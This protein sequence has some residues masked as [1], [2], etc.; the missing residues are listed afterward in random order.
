MPATCARKLYR[1]L[2]LPPGVATGSGRPCGC[3]MASFAPSL[4]QTRPALQNRTQLHRLASSSAASWVHR[5]ASPT[6]M[7]NGRDRLVK[8]SPMRPY[9]RG[10]RAPPLLQNKCSDSAIQRRRYCQHESCPPSSFTLCLHVPILRRDHWLSLFLHS[11]TAPAP[12]P[13]LLPTGTR[14]LARTAIAMPRAAVG[15]PQRASDS[16]KRVRTDAAATSNGGGARCGRR[17][18][19]PPGRE[20]VRGG[21]LHGHGAVRPGLQGERQHARVER[22]AAA[23][24]AEARGCQSAI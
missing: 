22:Q 10:W 17:G 21:S 5:R 18:A 2:L 6:S 9:L 3:R 12:V 14:R 15:C 13:S 23:A 7:E 11:T 20:L 1:H 24:K 19:R 8:V 4:L 16:R